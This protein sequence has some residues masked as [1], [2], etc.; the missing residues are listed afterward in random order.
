M[1]DR[2]LREF[3]RLDYHVTVKIL[4]AAHY[5]VPQERWRLILLGSRFSEIAPPEPTHYAA[6]RANFR[7][8]GGI[9]TF[10]LTDSD[11]HASCRRSPL[12]KRS[13]TCRAW[14]WG[15]GLRTVGYTAGAK[16]SEYARRCAT[17]KA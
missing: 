1:L 7:G 15:R 11:K 14:Q 3:A 5:G 12:A 10:Q 17:R 9:L 13:A 6:G 4:F 8:G 16:L 2:V